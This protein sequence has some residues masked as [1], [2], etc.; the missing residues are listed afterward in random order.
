DSDKMFQNE[1]SSAASSQ[2]LMKADAMPVG[3]VV[4]PEKYYIGPGDVIAIQDMSQLNT[5][6]PIVV[7]PDISVMIPRVGILSLKGKT[8]AETTE[9]IKST[10]TDKNPGAEVYITLYKARTVMIKIRGNVRLPG[11]Y[12]CPASYRVSTALELSNQ[13]INSTQT[14]MQQMPALLKQQ[15]EIQD[16]EKMFAGSGLSG[17]MDYASRNILV[18][19]RDGTSEI[20]DIEKGSVS[21]THDGDI[22]VREG[23]EIY[24]PYEANDYSVISISGQVYRPAV[25]PFKKGDK[26]SML[27]KL[28]LALTENADLNNVNL[29]LSLDRPKIQLKIDDNMNI[30][31]EDYD[32]LPGSSLIVG[33]SKVEKTVSFGK[34]SV[35]GEVGAPGV[36]I[37]KPGV[38]RVKEIIE[39][40]GGM[41]DKAYLP[42]AYVLRREANSFSSFNS[43]QEYFKK[44]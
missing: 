10:I 28:G 17:T 18:H 4:V 43:K 5:S 38:T 3:N 23:D 20:V 9:L 6:N 12:N 26:A 19:H 41:T 39:M 35:T 22:Y 8:L 34:V 30:I 25:L 24:I 33:K 15:E 29:I 42:L 11:I 31:G 27:L 32:L 44:L 21:E 2:K 16:S 40:A 7:T 13:E 37:I 1:L 36:Y 14:A